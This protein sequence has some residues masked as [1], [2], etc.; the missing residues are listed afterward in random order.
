MTQANTSTGWRRDIR[1]STVKSDPAS[2]ITSSWEWQDEHG[3]WNSYSPA[4]QR[5]LWACQRCGLHHWD[6]EAAGRR[7]KVEVQGGQGMLQTNLDTGVERKVRLT[8]VTGGASN[9]PASK[10]LQYSMWGQ[11]GVC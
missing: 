10:C 1:C 8:D 2:K 7:Y 5:L 4:V 9:P 6:I 3:G 11:L